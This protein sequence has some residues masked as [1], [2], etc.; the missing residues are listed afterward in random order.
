MKRQVSIDMLLVRIAEGYPLAELRYITRVLLSLLL[1][2]GNIGLFNLQAQQPAI[3]IIL[4]AGKT[5]GKSEYFVDYIYKYKPTPQGKDLNEDI[6]RLELGTSIVK[7]YSYRLW[8]A[9]SALTHAA[10]KSAPMRTP[11]GDLSPFWYYRDLT[12]GRTQVW[13]R[14]PLAGPT[15]RYMDTPTFTWSITG[16]KKTISGYETQLATCRFRGRSYE[17]W[18]TPSIPISAGP[19]LFGG[20]PGLI[21]ELRSTDGEHHFT[22]DALQK[23]SADI[24]EWKIRLVKEVS[25][26]QFRDYCQR[27]HKHPMQTF[28]SNGQRVYPQNEQ[29][30]FLSEAEAMDWQIPYNPIELE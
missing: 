5:L 9:D 10:N 11:D 7:S 8:Q 2:A 25:R 24:V 6:I 27:L 19:N 30:D 23:R 26:P 29:G 12:S 20:L 22:L 17:A 16:Q 3:P 21:L 14:T 18:F 28:K 13:Y 15:L 1:V 4:Q